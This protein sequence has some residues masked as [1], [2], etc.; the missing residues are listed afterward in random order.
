[1]LK[2]ASF[3]VLGRHEELAALGTF[4][5]SP[6]A[7]ALV[8]EGE[9]G[10]G[11]TTLWR[12]ALDM[13]DGL[14]QRV[15]ATRP[16]GA[17][18]QF[19]LSGVGD[20]LEGI[21]RNALCELPEIQ[22]RA[23]TVALAEESV[24]SEGLNGRVLGAA[25][26]NLTRVLAQ[27][28]PLVIAVDDLQWLDSAS[29]SVLLF[30]FRRLRDA[31][32]RLL[33]SCR[34]EPGA[35]LPFACEQALAEE[36]E[37][38]AVGP[39]SRG[40]I[41]RLIAERLGVSLP[42]TMLSAVC[43]TSGGNPFFALELARAGADGHADGL[44]RLPRNLELLVHERLRRL[45]AATREALAYVSALSSP[46]L[47]VLERTGESNALEPAIESGVVELEE[48][49][50]RFDHPLLAAAAWNAV[51]PKRKREIHRALSEAITDEEQRARHLALA[52]PGRD[53][54]VALALEGAAESA[55]RRAAPTAAAELFELARRLAPP[56]DDALWAR[57][58]ERAA[59]MHYE[60][61]EWERPL[62]LAREA[63]DRLP[64]GPER[65]AILLVACEMRP[66]RLDLSRQALDEAGDGVTR[67]R[68]L[69]ALA[70]QLAFEGHDLKASKVANEA[71]KLADRLERRDLL[72]VCL[73]YRAAMKM[74][75]ELPGVREDLAA[76]LEIEHELGQLP[77][78]L[79]N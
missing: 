19:S 63:L 25:F 42:L 28:K 24:E 4:F 70:E 55:R 1:M 77:T 53:A 8:L 47:E 69:L 64:P 56:R 2:A 49:R 65:A 60:A 62:E 16:A 17:E 61:G 57:L 23:L 74:Q 31:N 39:L 13:A 32:V 73:I 45:P 20:L 38:L 9:P 50:I 76:A 58:T 3:E 75:A 27:E 72:G 21:P 67:A 59:V 33:V 78:T 18:A 11:K 79:H 48:G 43:E 14:G 37:R 41:H 12:T 7:R 15:L 26:L 35:P 40:A 68:A 66:G 29:A 52:T 46:T 30:A 54:D 44:I 10:I 6:T 22:Q 51:G 34:G 71:C 36:I 5:S